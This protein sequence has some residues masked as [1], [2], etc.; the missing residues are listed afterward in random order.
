MSEPVLGQSTKH[1]LYLLFSWGG[2][3]GQQPWELAGDG[4]AS[5][6]PGELWHSSAMAQRVPH[7]ALGRDGTNR[8]LVWCPILFQGEW[9]VLWVPRGPYSAPASQRLGVSPELLPHFLAPASPASPSG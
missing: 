8:P 9:G 4:V 5:C 1:H 7:R 3:G 2:T 6:C